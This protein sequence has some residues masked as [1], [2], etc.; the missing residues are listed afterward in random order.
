MPDAAQIAQALAQDCYAVFTT[1]P[2]ARVLDWIKGKGHVGKTTLEAPAADQ[3]VDPI[4]WAVNEGKRIL[5]LE[6]MV[7]IELARRGTVPQ[8]TALT[9]AKEGT[10][11]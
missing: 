11:G 1:E 8:K 2:G 10:D 4:R 5:A 6:I 7:Q 9:G 3:P